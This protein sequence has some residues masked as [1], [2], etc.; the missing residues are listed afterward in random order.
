MSSVSRSNHKQRI[1]S[2]RSTDRKGFQYKALVLS[3][4]AALGFPVTALAQTAPPP[5]DNKVADAS[6]KETITVTGSRVTKTGDEQPTPV[7]V[8]PVQQMTEVVPGTLSEAINALPQF[9]GSQNSTSGPGSG[10]RNG[11]AAFITL[12]NAG[13]NHTLVLWD[14][15]RVLP[16]SPQES[17]ASDVDLNLIP[18]IL[19]QRVDIVTG[20]ASAVYG[21]DAVSGVVNFI[22]D[23][24]FTGFKVDAYTGQSTY[25]DG[26]ATHVGVAWGAKLFEG[27]GHVEASYEYH[28][29][30]G[31]LDPPDKYSRPFFSAVYGGSGLGTPADPFLLVPGQRIS[32]TSFGGRI[33]TATGA[34]G[35][36]N[37]LN[38]TQNSVLKPFVNGTPTTGSGSANIQGNGGDGAYY[39]DSTIKATLRSDKVF[40][41]FDYD[42]SGGTHG[43]AQAAVSNTQSLNYFQTTNLNF[44]VGLNNPYLDTVQVQNVPGLTQDQFNALRAANPNGVFRMTKFLTEQELG[45]PI[46][47]TMDFRALMGGLSGVVGEYDWEMHLGHSWADQKIENT[48]N[49]DVGKFF[50]AVDTVRNNAGNIVCRA[51]SANSAYADCVP[52]N[53]FGPTSANQAAINYIT[54]D[55]TA[56]THV[57][58]DE[59][60]STISGSPFST[61]AGP[62]RTALS[63]EWHRGTF[64]IQSNAEPNDK[65]DCNGMRFGTLSGNAVAG[66]CNGPNTNNP[67]IRWAQNTLTHL[68]QVAIDVYEAAAEAEVPLLRNAKWVKDLEMN[69][70]V[71]YTHYS[72]SGS[73]VPWKLG[74]VWLPD[75]SWRVRTTRSHDIRAPN[76]NEL[77]SP[78]AVNILQNFVDPTSG[79]SYAVVPR[80][81][82]SNPALKPEKAD[83]W[84]VGFVWSPIPNFSTAVDAWWIKM[85]DTLFQIRGNDVPV[86]N[87][88]ASSG[89]TSPYCAFYI[90]NSA[91][92]L[93]EVQGYILNIASQKTNGIDWETNYTTRL[94]G[95]RLDLRSFLVYQPNNTYNTGPGG[96]IEAA[97]SYIGAP[98]GVLSSPTVRAT[99]MGSFDITESLRFAVMEKWRNSMHAAAQVTPAPTTGYYYLNNYVPSVGYTNLTLTYYGQKHPTY[100]KWEVYAN[101]QNLFNKFSS[102]PVG[103]PP[104][105]IPGR[106]INPMPIGDDPVGRYY[107][108]GFRLRF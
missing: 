92:D 62:I 55:T 18:Q 41:R 64:S 22:T 16:A 73:A 78:P 58:L 5:A 13:D 39:I 100:G 104:T 59:F 9:G 69:A 44:N 31:I 2:P 72:T 96:I 77:Y 80:T 15:H 1:G 7:T 52:Y 53:V 25:H 82:Y 20:G 76:Y 79:R 91:G 19:M 24:N 63:A 103:G 17:H 89:G 66:N 29:D 6:P 14:G 107:T 8:V 10:I 33:T 12:R 68:D 27:R 86:Q 4:S 38:F 11:A 56:Y 47:N 3:V 83:T 35:P 26:Q 34:L 37:G 81:Q 70:A 67:T 49:V 57:K 36:L 94:Y 45:Q 98:A 48:G 85:K 106:G 54:F 60:Q 65:V 87:L 101:V 32:N 50:A 102:V 43:Y 99:I 90:H 74:L 97:G 75:E 105:N 51:A 21:S 108:V 93:I 23:K 30:K 61:K 42:F 71:R 88:C 40:A 95:H 46:R 84:T 28:D